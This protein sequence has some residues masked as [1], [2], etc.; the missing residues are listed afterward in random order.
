MKYLHQI[1]DTPEANLALDEALLDWAESGHCPGGLIRFWESPQY[2]VVLGF[3]NRASTETVGDRCLEDGIPVL[4]RISGGG[5]VLQGPGCLNYHLVLPINF[6]PD[7]SS[8]TSTNRFIMERIAGGLSDETGRPVTVEGYTDL[9]HQG[10]KFS[11]NAQRRKRHFLA[12]HGTIL[13]NFELS[14]IDQYLQFPSL[15]PD[16]RGSRPH[17]DF[18]GNFPSEPGDL[19]R[20]L[21]ECWDAG[22]AVQ[23]WELAEPLAMA[24]DLAR[25]KYSS[26]SWNNRV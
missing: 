17:L 24:E 14:L 12:F 19:I 4:R 21:R 6:H 18:V 1:Q 5:T 8:V 15:I 3:S 2:F 26:D 16:Y 7:L 10:R 22:D 25:S 11:G 20:I 23:P 9:V 13:Y